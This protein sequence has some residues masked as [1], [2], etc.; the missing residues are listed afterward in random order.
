MN[1]DVFFT[2]GST[3]KVCQDYGISANLENPFVIISDGCSTAPDSDYGSR[4]LTSAARQ[5]IDQAN[6]SDL[7]GFLYGTLSVANT[8][9]RTLGLPPE[10]L[11]ATLLIAKPCNDGGVETFCIGDGVV[12]GKTSAGEIYVYEYEFPS[13]GPYYLRYEIDQYIRHQ[14]WREMGQTAIQKSYIIQPDGSLTNIKE[15]VIQCESCEPVHFDGFFE[16]ERFDSVAIFSD[17][18]QSFIQQSNT[19]TSKSTKPVPAY[20]VIRELMA[21]KGCQGEF[22]HRRCSR[23][24]KGLQAKGIMHCDDLSMGVIY[25]GE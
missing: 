5:H 14:Y 24:L 3:H 20:E 22:V 15:T 4:L 19:L 7:R 13:G 18:I 10:S 9:C 25:L 6:L 2:I 12:A 1:A 17:G 11:S 16:Q 23:A 21:F 8:Y